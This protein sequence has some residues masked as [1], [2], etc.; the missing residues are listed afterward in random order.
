MNLAGIGRKLP[1]NHFQQRGFPATVS[2]DKPNLLGGVYLQVE[3]VKNH[4][5]PERHMYF[6]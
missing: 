1:E 5:R 3:P 6:F 2:P 4:L